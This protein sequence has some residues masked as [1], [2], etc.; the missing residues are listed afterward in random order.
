MEKET[1][2]GLVEAVVSGWVWAAQV[3]SVVLQMRLT[4]QRQGHT[5][6]KVLARSLDYLALVRRR[7]RQMSL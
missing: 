1:E 4:G 2:R 6:P 3:F 5:F 7:R